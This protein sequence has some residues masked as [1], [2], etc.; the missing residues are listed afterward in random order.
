MLIKL[1]FLE[2]S[3][4]KQAHGM[5]FSTKLERALL[6]SYNFKSQVKNKKCD[7]LC[8]L[9]LIVR[10]DLLLRPRL[11]RTAL[12]LCGVRDTPGPAAGCLRTPHCALRMTLWI[13]QP[14]LCPVS[15]LSRDPSAHHLGLKAST[16]RSKEKQKESKA[17]AALRASSRLLRSIHTTSTASCPDSPRPPPWARWD[18][19]PAAPCEGDARRPRRPTRLPAPLGATSRVG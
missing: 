4:P 17:E 13:P 1:L 5:K 9:P 6:I 2:L 14:S 19:G 16:P 3:Q 11:L 7:P 15:S 12:V 18:P 8:V 10:G